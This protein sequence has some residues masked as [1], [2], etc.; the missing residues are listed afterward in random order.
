MRGGGRPFA[1]FRLNMP[2][3]CA[4]IVL[5]LAGSVPGCERVGAD[6]R[7]TGGTVRQEKPQSAEGLGGYR[8]V[9]MPERARRHLVEADP[10][11]DGTAMYK[12]SVSGH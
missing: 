1:P 3:G 2:A 4:F 5:L 10:R 8:S 6:L 12:G 9:E 11:S 7:T